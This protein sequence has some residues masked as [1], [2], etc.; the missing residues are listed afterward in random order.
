MTWWMDQLVIRLIPPFPPFL[1]GYLYSHSH[2]PSVCMYA[3]DDV[4]MHVLSLDLPL[5]QMIETTEALNYTATASI[6]VSPY[7]TVT[8]HL[9]TN[10]TTCPLTSSPL[11][12]CQ[13]Q[14]HD[15][16]DHSLIPVPWRRIC[17]DSEH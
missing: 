5:G 4:A 8:R 16:S 10:Q 6:A 17:S 14:N 11:R 1:I 7:L 15:L 9:H 3:R 13:L 12:L 2:L